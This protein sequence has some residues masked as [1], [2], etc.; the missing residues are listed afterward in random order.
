MKKD[1]QVV[2]R[3]A[4]IP[5]ER[6]LNEEGVRNPPNNLADGVRVRSQGA[7]D[8]ARETAQELQDEMAQRGLPEAGVGRPFNEPFQAYDAEHTSIHPNNPPK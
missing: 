8:G 1:E 7:K 3:P 5:T 6:S 2:G 4:V